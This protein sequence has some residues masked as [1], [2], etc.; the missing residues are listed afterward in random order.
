MAT[1]EELFKKLHKDAQRGLTQALQP[2]E[3]IKALI[4]G[5]QHMVMAGTDRH[6]FVFKKGIT[7]GK[8][9]SKQLNSWDYLNVSGVQARTS[10]TTQVVVVDVFGVPPVTETGRLSSGQNSGWEAPNAIVLGKKVDVSRTIAH[11][12]T[13]IA[14]RH[15][16]S[17][18][19][20][21]QAAP[22]AIDQVRRLGELRDSG[23][24][25]EEEFQQK[26]R[27]L[28]GLKN[29]SRFA[30]PRTTR[31]CRCRPARAASA[32]R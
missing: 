12:R 21:V 16:A 20:P 19:T 24:L 30:S 13:L 15:Q 25:S 18:P 31:W 26:K 3:T 4:Q 7:S 23:L 8:F 22:D 27:D 1:V 28:L 14:E 17:S 11:L 6:V 2:G 9:F 32:R 5:E 10:L 29:A